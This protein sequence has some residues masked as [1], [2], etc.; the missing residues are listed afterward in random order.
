MELWVLNSGTLADSYGETNKKRAIQISSLNF[1]LKLSY[2]L[3][4]KDNSKD[5]V[6]SDKWSA[7]KMAS[8]YKSLQDVHKER[9]ISRLLYSPLS[10]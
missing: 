9:A 10:T 1:N 2:L 4:F 3:Q 5:C 8:F 6:F 7:I